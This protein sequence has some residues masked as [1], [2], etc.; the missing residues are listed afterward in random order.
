[1]FCELC[2]A[3]NAEDSGLLVASRS[4]FQEPGSLLVH[5]WLLI[6]EGL[7]ETSMLIFEVMPREGLISSGLKNIIPKCFESEACVHEENVGE[8][9]DSQSTSEPACQISARTAVSLDFVSSNDLK[10]LKHL[11]TAKVSNADASGIVFGRSTATTPRL[12]TQLG[13]NT[14]VGQRLPSSFTSAINISQPEQETNFP[15]VRTSPAR[16]YTVP[17]S[18]NKRA[19]LTPVL[20][21]VRTKNTAAE[22]THHVIG[23]SFSGSGHSKQKQ[24]QNTFSSIMDAVLPSGGNAG[25]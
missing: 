19:L 21:P 2:A 17:G 10:A 16:E 18:V 1:M 7:K 25:S 12:V 3:L 6:P 22:K 23:P 14:P 15:R 4:S 24:K 13:Q 8:V 20:P 11:A 5:Y 9:S